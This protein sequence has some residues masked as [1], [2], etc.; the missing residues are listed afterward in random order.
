MNYIKTYDN[1]INKD[2]CKRLIDH[3][4]DSSQAHF[5]G[6]MGANRYVNHDIKKCTEMY[7]SDNPD[8]NLSHIVENLFKEYINSVG[9]LG[10]NFETEPYRIKRYIADG[11]EFY[12][13]HVDIS[14]VSYSRRVSAIIIYLNDVEYGGETGFKINDNIFKVKP[15]AGS[16]VVFPANYCFPHCGFPPVSN[17]KYILTTFIRYA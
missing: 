9:T 11:S 5:E 3:F 4:S 16:A 8:I 2:I 14:S 13:W 7:I 15:Q 17:D 6:Y 1:V 10:G 12:N